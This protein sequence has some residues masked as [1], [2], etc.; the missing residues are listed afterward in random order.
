MSKVTV[1]I[2]VLFLVC[3]SSLA[4]AEPPK[5]PFLATV[6]GTVVKQ[7][8]I[9]PSEV[10]LRTSTLNNKRIFQEFQVSPTDYAL[11]VDTSI[12]LVLLPKSASSGKPAITVFELD[13]LSTFIDTR[14]KIGRF[15]SG[16][17]TST[18][19]DNLFEGLSGTAQ[20]PY[21]LTASQSVTKL[22]FSFFGRGSDIASD[23]GRTLLQ[24]KVTSG[25]SFIQKP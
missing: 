2:A 10:R 17:V 4:G 11:V 13:E 8:L 6:T 21:K 23:S 18:A 15:V 5:S 22:T 9:T 20:G 14:A 25:K 16:A 7:E 12:K 19:T 1:T 3:L 24:F